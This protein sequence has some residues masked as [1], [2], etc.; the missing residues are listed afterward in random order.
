MFGFCS[1]T[2]LYLHPL[3]GFLQHRFRKFLVRAVSMFKNR[4]KG[5]KGCQLGSTSN[6]DEEVRAGSER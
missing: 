1:N 3:F 5:I 2:A 6:K 4:A